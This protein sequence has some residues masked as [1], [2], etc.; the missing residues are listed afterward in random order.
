MSWFSTQK[1]HV[2]TDKKWVVVPPYCYHQNM[3]ELSF[4]TYQEA[5]EAAESWAKVNGRKDVFICE[6]VTVVSSKL[7]VETRSLR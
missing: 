5:L 2:E 1:E 3:D 7:E 6:K 4:A